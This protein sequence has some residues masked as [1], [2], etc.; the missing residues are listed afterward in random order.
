MNQ[1]Q[2]TSL[3]PEYSKIM[4]YIYM[5][6]NRDI[7]Y[8]SLP[9]LRMSTGFT[10]EQILAV[11]KYLSD[12]QYVE[13][14]IDPEEGDIRIQAFGG[15]FLISIANWNK[16]N[17]DLL[18]EIVFCYDQPTMEYLV[19]YLYCPLGIYN[20]STMYKFLD[21]NLDPNIKVK[22]PEEVK[23]QIEDTKLTAKKI[24]AALRK[25][26]E[27]RAKYLAVE[28]YNIINQKR[29]AIYP[30]ISLLNQETQEAM[31]LLTRFPEVPNTLF[32][33]GMGFL[34]EN[35]FYGKYITN[36]KSLTN[37]FPKFLLSQKGIKKKKS[38]MSLL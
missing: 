21:S 13:F 25:E 8:F 7:P 16:K 35:E 11:F 29:T 34:I 4:L 32:I 5:V 19:N 20:H 3:P 15:G 12:M 27:N 14:V 24:R 1:V 31:E 6:L 37:N 18:N 38:E 23:E 9:F 17:I 10:T 2:F 22:A 28:F 33:E 30:T 36:M 26:K